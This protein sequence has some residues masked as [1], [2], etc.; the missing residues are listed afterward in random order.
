MGIRTWLQRQDPWLAGL[1]ALAAVLFIGQVVWGALAY[2]YETGTGLLV[3]GLPAAASGMLFVVGFLLGRRFPSSGHSPGQLT[4]VGQ[5]TFDYLPSSPTENGWE[6]KVEATESQTETQKPGFALATDSHVPGTIRIEPRGR[7]CLDYKVPDNES[8]ANVIECVAKYEHNAKI[9]AQVRMT[10]RDRASKQSHGWLAFTVG[11]GAPKSLHEGE[12]H[13]PVQGQL[14]E[15]GWV[16]L[17]L[18]L[19]DAVSRTFGSRGYVY[20]RLLKLRVRGQI[21]LSPISLYRIGSDTGVR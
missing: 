1:S 11:S 5:I 12:W 10:S 3:V 4:Q 20:E 13:V 18:V 6:L 16:S 14:L 21:S 15:G 17:K 2:L 9:Y 8:L 19:D 7:Y